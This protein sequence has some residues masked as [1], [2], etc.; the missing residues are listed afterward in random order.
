M[1]AP[2]Q[3]RPLTATRPALLPQNSD[4]ALRKLL[5]DFFTVGG[6]LEEIRRQLAAR[7]RLSGPQFTILT[8]IGELEGTTGASVGQVAE[9]LHVTQ[10]FITIEARKLAQQA[11]ILKKPDSKDRRVCRLRVSRKG[12]SSLESLVPLLQRVNDVVFDLESRRQFEMLCATF[13]RLVESSARASAL[14]NSGVK[15]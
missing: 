10:S 1:A 12:R 7:I 9:Y 15:A 11:Y 4:H 13:D 2:A 5:Y 8:A 6:R 14:M 3:S